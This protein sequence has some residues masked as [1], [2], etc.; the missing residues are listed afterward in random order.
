MIAS[1]QSLVCVVAGC[2]H[3]DG[4]LACKEACQAAPIS[5]H[6]QCMQLAGLSI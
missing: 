6:M 3:R 2:R 4:M 5:V 1:I